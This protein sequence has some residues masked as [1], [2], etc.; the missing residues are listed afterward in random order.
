MSKNMQGW[1]DSSQFSG[2]N[3]AYLEDL[4]E[5][6]LHDANSVPEQWQQHFKDLPVINGNRSKD[7]PHSVI[8]DYFK[9]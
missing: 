4:Y 9:D 2:G 8:I 1:W 7:V 6:Y 5:Q 3:A